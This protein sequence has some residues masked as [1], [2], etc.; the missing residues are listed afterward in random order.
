MKTN[1]MLWSSVCVNCKPWIETLRSTAVV[2][3]GFASNSFKVV[4]TRGMVLEQLCPE[5][6]TT[7]CLYFGNPK[8]DSTFSM[9]W[10][11]VSVYHVLCTGRFPRVHWHLSA[12]LISSFLIKC[13]SALNWFLTTVVVPLA[14]NVSRHHSL[15]VIKSAKHSLS[16]Q[17]VLECFK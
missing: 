12:K 17:L 13:S 3:D 16:L 14:L 6:T 8:F 15:R 9:Q 7:T 5:Y 1:N 11:L 4:G 2:V 10:S